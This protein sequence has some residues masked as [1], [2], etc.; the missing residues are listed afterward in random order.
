[1][2]YSTNWFKITHSFWF[3]P[4]VYIFISIILAIV[5][6][7]IDFSFNNQTLKSS[8]PEVLLPDAELAAKLFSTLSTAT[9]TMTTIT[10][11]MI[12][13]VL[14]TFSG[15]FSPRTLQTFISDRMTQNVLAIFIS[16]FTYDIIVF[17]QLKSPNTKV[18]FISP[19]IAVI[20][21]IIAAI[22]FVLYI[23]HI[24]K[25]VQVNN[26]INRLTKEALQIVKQLDK[27]MVRLQK[28]NK[29][30]STHT[31]H[32]I[33]KEPI[34]LTANKT[35][36][37]DLIDF[38]SLL[39]LAKKHVASIKIEVYL[40]DYVITGSKLLTFEQYADNPLGEKNKYLH[41]I[42]LGAERTGVQDIEF[43][44]QKLDDIILKALSPATN[45]PTTAING[46]NRIGQILVSLSHKNWTHHDANKQPVL[47]RLTLK[48]RDFSFYLYK[49]FF[50]V[51]Y[52]S[53]D[54][55]AVTESILSTLK[56]IAQHAPSN[57]HETIWN[58]GKY[59]WA[60]FRKET[61]LDLD[62]SFLKQTLTDLAQATNHNVKDILDYP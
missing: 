34:T 53:N 1:M 49:A 56:L 52:S 61:L 2:K 16:G 44:I 19:I 13:V 7:Q 23:N 28:N 17:F 29:Q 35:G 3:L 5:T 51:S 43:A 31:N 42:Q 12:M 8:I 36:Y 46:I 32:E 62:E 38:N 37:V 41:A 4:I 10:F 50:Q 14:T 22:F 9:L 54:D 45:D 25:M 20:I 55:V 26:L 57:L 40:G 48:Q 33:T 18:L 58:Y 30:N 39:R 15:Q 60:G 11:S 59:V 27:D 6:V 24:A 47:E 21:A